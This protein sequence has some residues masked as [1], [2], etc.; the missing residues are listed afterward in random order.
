LRQQKWTHLKHLE[1]KV[2]KGSRNGG[3]SS[4]E[5]INWLDKSMQQFEHQKNNVWLKKRKAKF[6]PQYH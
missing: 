3:A 2:K 6:K 5:H 4:K 1:Q